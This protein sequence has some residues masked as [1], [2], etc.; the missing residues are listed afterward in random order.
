MCLTK[1]TRWGRGAQLS[2]RWLRLAQPR[3]PALHHGQTS[4]TASLQPGP[5]R[6]GPPIAALPE[7]RFHAA[8]PA[9]LAAPAGAWARS[10]GGAG[11]REP[12]Q[13]PGGTWVNAR[14]KGSAAVAR[15][16]SVASPSP[17]D[18]GVPVSSVS[19]RCTR[20]IPAGERLRIAA[21]G[22]RRQAQGCLSWGEAAGGSRA[23]RD[24]KNK[25]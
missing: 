15:I 21:L 22:P 1:L 24:P 3:R 23:K 20:S 11:L 10:Q 5:P 19:F 7:T 14:A 17:P 8:R 13:E 12:R 25:V 6:P 9:A 4:R 2:A 18:G 16:Q